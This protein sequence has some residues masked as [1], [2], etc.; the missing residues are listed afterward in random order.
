MGVHELMI[1]LKNS[2]LVATNLFNEDWLPIAAAFVI[3]FLPMILPKRRINRNERFRLRWALIHRTAALKIC[4][5]H[6]PG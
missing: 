6:V 5:S 2:E 4:T 3:N 1:S